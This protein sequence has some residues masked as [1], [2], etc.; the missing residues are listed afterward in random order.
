[1]SQDAIFTYHL[2]YE[3][4]EWS[5]S[6]K[7]VIKKWGRLHEDKDYNFKISH[8]GKYLFSYIYQEVETTNSNPVHLK[9][10]RIRDQFV[11]NFDHIWNDNIR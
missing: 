7:I 11:K 1:M 2:N 3:L 6:D 8:D 5:I 4:V 9:Q 10:W